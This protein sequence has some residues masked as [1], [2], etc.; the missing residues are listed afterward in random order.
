[1]PAGTLVL[2]HTVERSIGQALIADPYIRAVVFTGSRSRGLAIMA[3]AAKRKQPIPVYAEMSSIN[4]VLLLPVALKENASAIAT[5][6]ITSLT[7]G[8]GQFCTNPGLILAIAIKGLEVFLKAA[9]D[10]VRKQEPQTM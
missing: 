10:A 2:L 9:V 1:M 7:L 4:P 6:F 8:A 5:S 3:V